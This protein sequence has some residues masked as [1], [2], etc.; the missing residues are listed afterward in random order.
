MSGA[1]H[2][3]FHLFKHRLKE[4]PISDSK[5]SAARTANGVFEAWEKRTAPVKL[6]MNAESATND[7]KTARLRALRLAKEAEDNETAR[8]AAAN[9][10]SA[11]VKK[12]VK[13][14]G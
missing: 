7:A 6:Q 1:R 13:R 9:S 11:L 12:R 14:G 4:M 10:P 8:I 3:P 2:V 5:N